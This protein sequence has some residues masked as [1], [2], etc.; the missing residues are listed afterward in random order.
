MNLFIDG[1]WVEITYTMKIWLDLTVLLNNRVASQNTILCSLQCT[2][3][4][5]ASYKMA[6]IL[7]SFIMCALVHSGHIGEEGLSREE[8]K[9]DA[10][11]LFIPFLHLPAHYEASKQAHG[12]YDSG[13]HRYDDP[14]KTRFLQIAVHGNVRT[15]HRHVRVWS[16][17]RFARRDFTHVKSKG[18]GERAGRVEVLK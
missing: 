13:D 8:M 14:K 17:R 4:L 9:W 1:T 12:E 18:F 16:S 11:Q 5:F 10:T 7:G 6:E 2:L 3:P 15:L